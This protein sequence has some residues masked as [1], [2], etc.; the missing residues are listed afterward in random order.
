MRAIFCLIPLFAAAWTHACTAASADV[1]EATLTDAV[2]NE[3]LGYLGPESAGW[4]G[5]RAPETTR[6]GTRRA[7]SEDPTRAF[8]LSRGEGSR[9]V[10]TA[11]DYD[12]TS[13]LPIS[14]HY[15][16]SSSEESIQQT[17]RRAAS[18]PEPSTLALMS[19]GFAAVLWSGWRA[20]RAR[21]RPA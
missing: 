12:A 4:A 21:R 5:D 17:Q 8:V 1:I 15:D 11:F 13:S 3:T 7:S 9:I 18:V 20:K 2:A 14:F 19:V 6:F 16:V 10:F